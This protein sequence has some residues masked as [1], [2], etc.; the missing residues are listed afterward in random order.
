MLCPNP[1]TCR[2]LRK[3]VKGAGRGGKAE[4]AQPGH[5]VQ[6]N[7]GGQPIALVA[8]TIAVDARHLG[9]SGSEAVRLQTS[10]LLGRG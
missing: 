3:S 1:G 10:L 6:A 2:P 5:A 9:P 4:T 7:A 8:T